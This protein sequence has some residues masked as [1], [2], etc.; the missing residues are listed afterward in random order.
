[1]AKREKKEQERQRR[2]EEEEERTAVAEGDGIPVQDLLSSVGGE[3]TELQEESRGGCGL[4]ALQDGQ[5]EHMSEG[6]PPCVPP[7]CT[8]GCLMQ[9]V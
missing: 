3:D 6:R 9:T 8:V 1:M 7:S 4:T 2:W 5:G